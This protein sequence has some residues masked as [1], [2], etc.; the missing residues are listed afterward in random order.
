MSIA[1]SDGRDASMKGCPMATTEQILEDAKKIG[2][3]I[4]DHETTRRFEAAVKKLDS[5]PT[6]QQTMGAY[7]QLI[8]KLGQK[9]MSGQPIEVAEKRQLQEVQNSLV[10]N[11]TLR[12]FQMAQVE[13]T[14]LLRKVDEAINSEAVDVMAGPLG[15]GEPSGPGGMPGG[16][17]IIG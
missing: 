14:D 2:K 15:G 7:Q 4:A 17:P 6:V 9:E 3:L 11:L 13:Y 1:M 8:Q 5:D 12:E 16:S 10:H